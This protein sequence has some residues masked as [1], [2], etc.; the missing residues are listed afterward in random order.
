MWNKVYIKVNDFKKITGL[1][2]ARFTE[3]RSA[4]EPLSAALHFFFGLP[5][6]CR[7]NNLYEESKKYHLHCG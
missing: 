1:K 2:I 7:K 4:G 6:N 5:D 3:P